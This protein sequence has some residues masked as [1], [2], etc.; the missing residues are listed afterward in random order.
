M[1]VWRSDSILVNYPKYDNS[2][3]G[4]LL[5]LLTLLL[6]LSGGGA[7]FHFIQ[8]RIHCFALATYGDGSMK[9]HVAGGVRQLNADVSEFFRKLLD[10]YVNVQRRRLRMSHRLLL[11]M[12]F[13]HTRFHRHVC[14]DIC[15]RIH[16]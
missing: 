2:G 11:L 14:R 9:F 12:H 6:L 16:A 3:G 15:Q 5:L 4:W 10:K 1:C 7:N 13:A 8:W